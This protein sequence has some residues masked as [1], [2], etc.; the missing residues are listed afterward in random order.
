MI[1]RVDNT[2]PRNTGLVRRGGGFRATDTRFSGRGVTSDG[3]A[4]RQHVARGP[5]RAPAVV[6][7]SRI[8]RSFDTPITGRFAVYQHQDTQPLGQYIDTWV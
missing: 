3:P 6:E 8:E 1:R 4:H 7:V 5:D 2:N